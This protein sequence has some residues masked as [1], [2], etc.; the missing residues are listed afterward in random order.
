MDIS[1]K[2]TIIIFILLFTTSCAHPSKYSKIIEEFNSLK[3]VLKQQA[4][5]EAQTSNEF[6]KILIK[7]KKLALAQQKKQDELFKPF[8]RHQRLIIKAFS[9]CSSGTVTIK[10]FHIAKY[11]KKYLERIGTQDHKDLFILEGF[12]D[13]L[14]T[15][16]RPYK[17]FRP[18][19]LE[20]GEGLQPGLFSEVRLTFEL[21]D[22]I[23]P[24]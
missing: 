3:T 22:Q 8:S 7:E 13:F 5:L 20:E 2:S 23:T 21:L 9:I 19:F 6:V 14:Y 16:I 4:E 17:I 12:F 1:R 15:N 10:D 18:G 24:Q 11:L